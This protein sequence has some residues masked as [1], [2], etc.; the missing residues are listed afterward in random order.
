[1]G[2][3]FQKEIR[4]RGRGNRCLFVSCKVFWLELRGKPQVQACT[5]YMV[6]PMVWAVGK[7]V[8]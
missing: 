6:L 8:A 4:A 3:F 2:I 1:M 7:G 5:F